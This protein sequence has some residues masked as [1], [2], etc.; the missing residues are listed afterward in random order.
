MEY[1]GKTFLTVKETVRITGLSAGYIRRG[2][3]S[4]IVPH[5]VSGN[6]FLINAPMLIEKLNRE[7]R[8]G[9]EA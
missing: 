6:K 7:S 4:G 1:Q 2:C 5:I 3:N 8:K 9:Q